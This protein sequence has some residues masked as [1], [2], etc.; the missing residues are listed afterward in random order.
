MT[1]NETMQKHF[2]G[3]RPLDIRQNTLLAEVRTLKPKTHRKEVAR[4]GNMAT[5][6]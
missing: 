4:T 5:S 1:Q 6:H 2:E 3:Q